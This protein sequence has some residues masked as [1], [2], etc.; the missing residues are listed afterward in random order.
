ML[1]GLVKSNLDIELG[2]CGAGPVPFMVRSS[3]G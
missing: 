2:S 1:A 3:I